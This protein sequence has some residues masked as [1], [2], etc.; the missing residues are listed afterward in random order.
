MDNKTLVAIFAG[1]A[2]LCM[3]VLGVALIVSGGTD[4]NSTPGPMMTSTP[5][6]TPTNDPLRDILEQTWNKQSPAE[7]A[8]LCAYFNANPDGAYDS[9]VDGAGG[10][11][12]PEATFDEFLS[13]ECSTF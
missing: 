3:T 10:A 1:V 7:Q 11:I 6:P 13:S 2:L 4:D 9:F 12:L 8:L 5:A